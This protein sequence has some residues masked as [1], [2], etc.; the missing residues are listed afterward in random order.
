MFLRSHL[1]QNEKYKHF[2]NLFFKVSIL[3][4]PYKTKKLNILVFPCDQKQ[5]QKRKPTSQ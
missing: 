5:K 1:A 4:K 3:I 2:R